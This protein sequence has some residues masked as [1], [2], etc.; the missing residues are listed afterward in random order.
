MKA[1]TAIALVFLLAILATLGNAV[2]GGQDDETYL[3]IQCMDSTFPTERFQTNT[4]ALLVKGWRYTDVP[5]NRARVMTGWQTSR[6]CRIS[7]TNTGVYVYT[8]SLMNMRGEQISAYSRAQQ[9]AIIAKIE[10]GDPTVMAD[11]VIDTTAWLYANGTTNKAQ[12]VE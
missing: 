3:V 12:S 6:W 2:F 4:A 9:K 5:E 11:F 8:A 7:N 10:N 1:T